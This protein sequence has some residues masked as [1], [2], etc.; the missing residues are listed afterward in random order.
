MNNYQ[1]PAKWTLLRRALGVDKYGNGTDVI[2]INT[3]LVEQLQSETKSLLDS[4]E[5][6]RIQSEAVKKY[7]DNASKIL[8]SALDS[9]LDEDVLQ[10]SLEFVEDGIDFYSRDELANA[11]QRFKNKVQYEA[12][13]KFKKDATNTSYLDVIKKEREEARADAV[14]KYKR[15]H[16]QL[17]LDIE[18]IIQIRADERKKFSKELFDIEFEVF[19]RA[20]PKNHNERLKEFAERVMTLRH[21]YNQLKQPVE[22]KSN[23]QKSIEDTNKLIESFQRKEDERK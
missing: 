16:A 3:D 17:E 7:Q 12:V 5:I 19:N 11:M 1:P 22:K 10:F 8:K 20:N 9:P 18:A 15:E 2:F 14:E 13:E 23:F 4:R 6:S 21:K